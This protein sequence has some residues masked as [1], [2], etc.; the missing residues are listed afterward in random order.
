[1]NIYEDKIAMALDLLPMSAD[2]QTYPDDTIPFK[3]SGGGFLKKYRELHGSTWVGRKH[4][5][6]TLDLKSKKMVEFYNSDIGMERRKILSEKLKSNPI[7][8]G[9]GYSL[10]TK[11]W[12]NGVIDKRCVDCP[13]DGFAEGRIKWS[14]RER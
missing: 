4:K 7:G 14:K 10:G 12:N 1:M 3:E 11:W 8:T 5:P 2:P 9:V 13:G 6:E